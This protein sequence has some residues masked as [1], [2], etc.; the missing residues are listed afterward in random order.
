VTNGCA[1]IPPAAHAQVK[2]LLDQMMALAPSEPHLRKRM[3][4]AR[5][6]IEVLTESFM[7]PE[8]PVDWTSYGLTSRETRIMELLHS[9]PGKNFTREQIYDAMYFDRCGDGP[10]IKII[11]IFVCKIRGKFRA[12]NAE[13]YIETWWGKGYRLV[14]YNPQIHQGGGRQVTGMEAALSRALAAA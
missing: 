4:A 9:R 6:S 12:L 5:D 3:A 10:D 1:T 7:R 8:G 11:D 13:H 14:P 2:A